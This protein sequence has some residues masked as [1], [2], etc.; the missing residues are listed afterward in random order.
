[1]V[2]RKLLILGTRYDVFLAARHDASINP[3]EQAN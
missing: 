2:Y 3:M 1:M